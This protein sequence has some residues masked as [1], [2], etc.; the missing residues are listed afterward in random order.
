MLQTNLPLDKAAG[1]QPRCINHWILQPHLSGSSARC[2]WGDKPPHSW[3]K[4]WSAQR[5]SRCQWSLQANH[6]L[7]LDDRL[8]FHVN[9]ESTWLPV[10]KWHALQERKP[11]KLVMEAC[12][13]LE[14]SHA[15][16][17]IKCA[18]AELPK[19]CTCLNTPLGSFSLFDTMLAF[20]KLVLWD[21][22]LGFARRMG[23]CNKDPSQ[24]HT[25]D[26]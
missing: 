26:I 17:W 2:W 5:S 22:G 16:P 11:S 13:F 15:Q 1:H 19:D 6:C 20:F 18:K 7:L 9:H 10:Q 25:F 3:S 24:W 21:T 8:G 14:A 4:D 12:V 23:C